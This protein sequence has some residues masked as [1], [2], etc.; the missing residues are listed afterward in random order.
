MHCVFAGNSSSNYA[1]WKKIQSVLSDDELVLMLLKKKRNLQ[2]LDS[3]LNS[4]EKAA[5]EGISFFNPGVEAVSQSLL[6]ICRLA[7][8]C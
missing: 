3:A 2:I 7:C 6:H 1:L 8:F 4:H 5:A